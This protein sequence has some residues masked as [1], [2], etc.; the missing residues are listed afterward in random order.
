MYNFLG[1]IPLSQGD[2]D[3]AARLLGQG[4]EAARRVPDRFPLLISLYDLALS[5]QARGD[6]GGAAALLREGLSVASGAG[7]DSSV[8]YYLQRLAAL[9]AQREDPHRAVR[10]LAAADALLQAAGTG[11]LLAYVAG[12]PAE[13][14]VLPELRRRLGE[15]A[16]QHAWA[17]GAAM[18]RDHAVEYAQD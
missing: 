1:Q 4:L 8:G 7:D 6:L 17:E 3:A 16:F 13:A 10:L 2:N 15:A 14:D 11:W 5:S 12:A 18:G 9:A